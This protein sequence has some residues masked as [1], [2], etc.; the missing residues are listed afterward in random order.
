M[1]VEVID[2]IKPKNGGSFPIVEAV[3]VEVSEGLR[4]SEALEA[5]ANTADVT[6]ETTY[7]QSQIDQI[8]QAAGSGS[9]DT[10]V[11][12]ARVGSD[13]TSYNTL[14]NRLDAEN[15]ATEKHYDAIITNSNV[16]SILESDFNNIRS[17]ML[18]RIQLTA[19]VAGLPDNFPYD[20]QMYY[21]IR[22]ENSLGGTAGYAKH[23]VI[24]NRNLFPMFR[25][26]VENNVDYGWKR[27]SEV[28]GIPNKLLYSSAWADINYDLNDA[29]DNVL[30]EFMLRNADNISHLPDGL[31]VDKAFLLFTFR[32][33]YSGTV[34]KVQYIFER[35]T[36]KQL[37]RR[38]YDTSWYSWKAIRSGNAVILNKLMFGTALEDLDYD[39]DN[40][41]DN[42]MYELM[43]QASDNVRNLPTG[44]PLGKSCL[45]FTVRFDHNGTV[46]KVQY[47]FERSTFKPLYRRD[48]DVSWYPWRAVTIGN[49]T[50]LN[51]LM[52]GTALEDLGY[53][54][55]NAADN[56]M[57]ELIIKAAD[58]VSNLPTG[59]PLE[60]SCLLFTLR[61]D[62]GSTVRKVQ[63]IFD[64]KTFR[65]LYRRDFDV[66][67][68][69]WKPVAD[70]N[71][72]RKI[73]VDISGNGDY[74][75]LTDALSNAYN[76]GNTDI[77][78]QAG[79]YDITSEIDLA[80]A[81]SGPLIG[82]NTRLYFS[83]DSEVVC[84]YTG[85][86]DDVE[87]IFS[88]INAGTG[89]YEIHDMRIR[90]KNV[91]YCVHD[92]RSTNEDYYTHKYINCNMYL[93]DAN[94]ISW[95]T[96]QCIGG[97]LGKHGII[98]ISGG[99]YRSTY[100]SD[101]GD[102][103]EITYHNSAAIDAQSKIT[104]SNVYFTNTARF[105]CY[106]STTKMTHCN[107]NNCSVSKVPTVYYGDIS[108]V[109]NM[110]M[111]AYNNELRS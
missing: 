89:D 29:A 97:G 91:R 99:E 84:E 66:S 53:D 111:V 102:M 57:Y 11:A 73:T 10:E 6:E 21:I 54:L 86:V 59:Y 2:K 41:E 108:S 7:L 5:K 85:G 58:N 63:Y 37:Y 47:I 31:P 12:Q 33:D 3:D 27:H 90:C 109:T 60:Q 38:D 75:K 39:L 100:L 68:Y 28:L 105:I 88:P 76:N 65:Q 80:E 82:N 67:W 4:L 55:N 16:A 17:N 50:V 18:Y 25:R 96:Q 78:V 19:T 49:V 110:E 107:I 1:A 22:Y 71:Y 23:Y 69:S 94:A 44:Y 87:R 43:I 46:R 14:K 35:S 26:D 103:G 32:C 52:F 13:G 9:A 20:G 93:D 48:F 24:Y 95:K 83:P 79:T 104:I 15:I 72:R 8:A 34:R 77:Y 56:V 42:V 106:G 74:T 51:K 36:F 101:R 61:F 62:Y 92:E 98:D 70:T 81:G 64:R 45:L 30:Y 40:A